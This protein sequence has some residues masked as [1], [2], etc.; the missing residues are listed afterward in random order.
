VDCAELK[1]RAF[2]PGL[3]TN[4]TLKERHLTACELGDDGIRLIADA[5][6]G[7][8]TMDTLD[9]SWNSITSAGLADITRILMLTVGIVLLLLVLPLSPGS[10]C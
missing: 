6:V 9:I 3:Q 5:L 10:S 4:R 7:N 1:E 8:A 2:Q